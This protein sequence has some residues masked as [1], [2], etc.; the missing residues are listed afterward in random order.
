MKH[1][2]AALST[3]CAIT[4]FGQTANNTDR[5]NDKNI[6]YQSLA[7]YVHFMTTDPYYSKNSNVDTLYIEK[8]TCPTDSLINH[9]GKTTIVMVEDPYSFLQDQH[10]ERITLFRIFPMAYQDGE[11]SVS[12]VPFGVK[13]DTKKKMLRYTNAGSFEVKYKFTDLQFHFTSIENH[14]I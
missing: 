14:G 4:A 3:I 7:R 8:R 5:L 2:L 9:I 10:R 6:Y 1:L 11:F 13:A 12:F